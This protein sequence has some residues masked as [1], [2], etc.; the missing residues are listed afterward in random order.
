MYNVEGRIGTYT[1]H[2]VEVVN[3]KPNDAIILHLTEEVDLETANMLIKDIQAAFP[4][5]SVLATHPL[6]IEGITIAKQESV[7]YEHP[8]L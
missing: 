5:Q 7:D 1:G 2:P 4:N 8:M 6:L 3:L